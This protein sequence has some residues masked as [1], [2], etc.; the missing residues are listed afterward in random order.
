MTKEMPEV[1]PRK[2][3]S[4]HELMQPDSLSRTAPSDGAK[5]GRNIGLC[6]L[7]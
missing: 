3:E 1:V 6:F 5:P 4:P 7:Q 2:Q